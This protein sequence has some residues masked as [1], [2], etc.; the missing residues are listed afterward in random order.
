MESSI[1]ELRIGEIVSIKTINL[2][3][4]T[5]NSEAI[6]IALLY[7]ILSDSVR[8]DFIFWIKILSK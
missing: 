6:L 7:A 4:E 3:C 8:S 2:I 5:D 1:V